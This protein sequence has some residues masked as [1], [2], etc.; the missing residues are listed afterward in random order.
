MSQ[1]H[2]VKERVRQNICAANPM[3]Q[4]GEENEYYCKNRD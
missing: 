4:N 1:I 2:A 3:R